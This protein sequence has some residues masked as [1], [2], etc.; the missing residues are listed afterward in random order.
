MLEGRVGVL[1]MHDNV[2][3]DIARHNEVQVVL[4]WH[5]VILRHT[6]LHVLEHG[7]HVALHLT[8]GDSIVAHRTHL[9][10]NAGQRVFPVAG[11]RVHGDGGDRTTLAERVAMV[12]LHWRMVR[13]V[14][15]DNPELQHA[16]E[17]THCDKMTNVLERLQRSDRSLGIE[18]QLEALEQLIAED[19]QR[20][21]PRD[22]TRLCVKRGSRR[23]RIL[24]ADHGQAEVVQL[25][26][27]LASDLAAVERALVG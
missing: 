5:R 10:H 8:L 26:R 3:E 21:M 2:L 20:P 4:R 14:P 9:L 24:G 23:V 11:I 6:L 17:D 15:R 27:A 18:V 1:G 22:A 7:I 12:D 13:A 16:N 19:L 25:L